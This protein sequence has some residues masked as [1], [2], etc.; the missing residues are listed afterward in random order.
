MYVP[1]LIQQRLR[2]QMNYFYSQLESLLIVLQ[3][4]MCLC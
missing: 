2:K 1:Q 4:K 3:T